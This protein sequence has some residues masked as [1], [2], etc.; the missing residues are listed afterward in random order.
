ML[1]PSPKEDGNYF[2]QCPTSFS[3]PKLKAFQNKVHTSS[4]GK[5]VAAA[6]VFQ[7]ITV[8]LWNPSV[9][10]VTYSVFF[11]LVGI[12]KAALKEC[13]AITLELFLRAGVL[14]EDEDGSWQLAED[15]KSRRIYLVVDAKTVEKIVK[16]VRDM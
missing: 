3:R 8:R 7:H 13:G 14:E 12:D 6:R 5:L 1:F 10:D 2:D 4:G 11:G 16:F 9:D 15:Y